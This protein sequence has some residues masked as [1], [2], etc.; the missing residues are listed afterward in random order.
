MLRVPANATRT[1]E[2][3]AMGAAVLDLCD[4]QRRVTQIVQAFGKR[5]KL[6]PHEA[7]SATIGFLRTL[8]QRG[9]IAMVIDAA[10]SPDESTNDRAG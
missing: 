5:F 9:V 3:D 6:D 7:H 10:T 4:G 2:L 8:I 1:F